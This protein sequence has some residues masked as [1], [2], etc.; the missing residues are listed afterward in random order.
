M[1]K[2]LVV[3]SCVLVLAGCDRKEEQTK[4]KSGWKY[5]TRPDKWAEPRI[6][7]GVFDQE[8]AARISISRVALVDA[9]APKEISPNKAYW[10][11]AHCPDRMKPGPYDFTADI[12]NERDYLV[13]L[14]VSDVSGSYRTKVRWINEKLL[15]AR[16]WW[17]RVKGVD[18]IV[19]V[20]S[21]SII[22]KEDV[23][24]GGIPF[25]QWQQAKTCQVGQ[26]YSCV[27][28]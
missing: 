19:D 8:Y 26:C 28:E 16:V 21:E 9:N 12:Y 20:E 15:H 24:W 10:F 5:H 4:A 23:Y 27:P 2:M 11:S 13:K 14:R 3:V 1:R 18:F 6:Y 22:H 25:Q 7:H 17:G